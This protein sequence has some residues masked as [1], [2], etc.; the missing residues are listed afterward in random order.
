MI[1]ER[2]RNNSGHSHG[3]RDLLK[4]GKKTKVNEREVTDDDNTLVEEM[5]EEESTE[6]E[7]EYTDTDGE[8]HEDTYKEEFMNEPG[9]RQR[10][11]NNKTV[12]FIISNKKVGKYLINGGLPLNKI[13]HLFHDYSVRQKFVIAP[14][15]SV[16]HNQTQL[17]FS[18]SNV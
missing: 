14:W 9:N 3:V 10:F 11:K 4:E 2:A 16:N 5:D 18:I 12:G 7:E 17:L 13:D 8:E 6:D 1:H 15:V